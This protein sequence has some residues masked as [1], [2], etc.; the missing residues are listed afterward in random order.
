MTTET[1]LPDGFKVLVDAPYDGCAEEWCWVPIAFAATE[2]DAIALA[3]AEGVV[4]DTLD[5]I[6]HGKEWWRRDP[7]F[8]PTD[9][10][11]WRN[12]REDIEVDYEPWLP[13]TKR[14]KSGIEVWRLEVTDDA[15]VAIPSS[16]LSPK[17]DS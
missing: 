12:E 1:L 14:A 16:R 2:D 13:C 7:A 15:S 3:R 10:G 4:Y 11:T 5:L 17:E 6:P 9:D 8:K